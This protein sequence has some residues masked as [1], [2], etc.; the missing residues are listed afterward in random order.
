MSNSLFAIIINEISSAVAPLAGM[1]A[2]RADGSIDVQKCS[3]NVEKLLN[4][5][6]FKPPSTEAYMDLAA[7]LSAAA[8]A[9]ADILDR[10]GADDGM[11]LIGL[12]KDLLP[13]L[14]NTFPAIRDAVSRFRNGDFGNANEQMRRFMTVTDFADTFPRRLIDYL[15]LSH[16]KRNYMKVYSILL[17]AGLARN[18]EQAENE[19]EFK[20]ECVLQVLNWEAIPDIFRDPLSIPAEAFDFGGSFNAENFMACLE[21]IIRSFGLPGGLYPTADEMLSEYGF[22]TG[23]DGQSEDRPK[24]MRMPVF[25]S[26]DLDQGN[27]SALNLCMAPIRDMV[28]SQEIAYKGIGAYFSGSLSG[29]V[30]LGDAWSLGITGEMDKSVLVKIT[31]GNIETQ[32][33]TDT[34]S[35]FSGKLAVKLS[36]QPDKPVVLLGFA[37]VLSIGFKGLAFSASVEKNTGGTGCCVEADVTGLVLQIKSGDGDSF[38]QK[39]L[40]SDINVS[41]DIGFGYSKARNFYIKSGSEGQDGE[42]NYTWHLNKELGPVYIRDIIFAL[43]SENKK[44]KASAAV[45]ARAELGP[46][47]FLVEKLGLYIVVD[48]EKPG[49]LGKADMYL[50]FKPPE[51]VGVNIEAPAVT[52]GGYLSVNDTGYEGILNISIGEKFSV[53]AIGILTTKTP[54]GG[55]YYSLKIIGNVVFPPVQLGYGFFLRGVGI[56]AAINSGMNVTALQNSV[57]DGSISSILFPPDPVKNAP[58]IIKNIKTFLPP[59]EGSHLFG[60]MVKIGWGGA[61]AIL[62]GELGI[63]IQAGRNFKVAIAGILRA[64]L[65]RPDSKVISL[66]FAVIGML[67]PEEEMISIDA[68]LYNSYLLTW[69]ISGDMALRLCYGNNPYFAMS[70]GGFYPGYRAPAG[71]P[72]LRRFAVNLGKNN[73]RITLDSYLAIT[74]NSVQFGAK[75]DLLLVKDVKAIGRFKLE[76]SCGFDALIQFRPRFYFECAMFLRMAVSA[77]GKRLAYAKLEGRLSGPNEFHIKGVCEASL[78]GLSLEFDVDERFG[79]RISEPET[80]KINALALLRGE[81]ADV[82]NWVPTVSPLTGTCVAF[83]HGEDAERYLDT[84]GGIDFNQNLM[85]LEREIEKLGE[86]RIEGGKAYFVIEP[87]VPGAEVQDI[88]KLESNFAPGMFVYLSDSQ[89]LS[90]PAFVKMPSGF[91]VSAG[92]LSVPS[93]SVRA[94]QGFEIILVSDDDAAAEVPGGMRGHV[95]RGMQVYRGMSL[96]QVYTGVMAEK[97]ALV[98]KGRR[99]YVGLSRPGRRTAEKRQT[100]YIVEYY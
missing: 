43:K 93:G 48:T 38:I 39:I 37:D 56:A 35:A 65:P 58:V 83:R 80:P 1:L 60:V 57:R 68:S 95:R 22:I 11:D 85:P 89:K 36:Y 90:G 78:C 70:A 17:L 14:K 50:D 69:S 31:P 6:G 45:C 55:N 87:L 9:V 72:Q 21:L 12:A 74:D 3:K 15:I 96:N 26:G 73:P 91:S 76:G 19:A 7:G 77:G 41:F 33:L 27:Y 81:I 20:S 34:N 63:F 67:D 8:G 94:E 42:L 44:I 88:S 18:I 13:V 64:V 2:R 54:D 98:H 32:I 84:G 49:V 52:G 75:L 29:S 86:S 47:S 99:P 23:D 61:V 79:D 92:G 5:T 51:A 10:L 62:D 28:N 30:A 40:P 82:A 46:V 97:A 16:L 100:G 71:F 24:E 25:T 53:T 66:N 4:E 59:C